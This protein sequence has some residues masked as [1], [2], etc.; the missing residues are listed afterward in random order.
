MSLA[1]EK[2]F[3][4]VDHMGNISVYFIEIATEHCKF[5]I[6]SFPFDKQNCS[7][8]YGSWMYNGLQINWTTLN[9]YGDT[10]YAMKPPPPLP[11]IVPFVYRNSA[12]I[13]DT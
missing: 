2:T 12:K 3:A 8:H 5:D 1:T 10:R 11:D 13:G 9:P 7:F 6:D 4:I